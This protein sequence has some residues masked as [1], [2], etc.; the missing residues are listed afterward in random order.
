M[1]GMQNWLRTS[2]LGLTLLG[3]A[4]PLAAQSTSADD[5][6]AV[7]WPTVRYDWTTKLTGGVLIQPPFRGRLD[8]LLGVVNIGTGGFKAGVGAGWM[9]G[10]LAFGY[11]VLLTV[12][13]TNDHPQGA[14][15]N[16]TFLGVEGFIPVAPGFG[17]RV[18]PAFR[19]GGQTP[20]LRQGPGGQAAAGRFRMNVSLG[21]GY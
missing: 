3:M 8:P 7:I 12:T 13:R 4:L 10:N 14:H 19:V 16:Q 17:L 1:P 9:G 6:E 5:D 20:G 2:I 11:G 21:F 18:G 15:R